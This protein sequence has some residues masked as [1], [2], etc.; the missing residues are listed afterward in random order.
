MAVNKIR[1]TKYTADRGWDLPRLFS[2]RGPRRRREFGGVVPLFIE[3]S[4]F[5][6][7]NLFV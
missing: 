6:Q 4:F 3:H 2:A 1:L 7:P 5:D